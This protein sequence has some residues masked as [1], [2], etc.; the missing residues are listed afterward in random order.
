MKSKI[1][2]IAYAVLA[3]S[4]FTPPAERSKSGLDL[5]AIDKSVSPATDIYLYAN[6]TWLKNNP[7]PAEEARWGS[8]DELRLLNTK[9]VL[10]FSDK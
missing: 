2:F 5:K 4:A 9:D 8:F 10:F 6:G 3:L 1:L 7:V